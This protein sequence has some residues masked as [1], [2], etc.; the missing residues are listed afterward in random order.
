[1]PFSL[2]M[3]AR[4]IRHRPRVSIVAAGGVAVAV[5]V[6]VIVMGITGGLHDYLIGRLLGLEAHLELLAGVDLPL[7]GFEEL[8]LAVGKEPYVQSVEPYVQGQVLVGRPGSLP[9]GAY[10]RGLEDPQVRLA[11]YLTVNSQDE[12]GI[13]IGEDLAMA[14][15]LEPGSEAV[16]IGGLENSRSFAVRGLFRTGLEGYDGGMVYLTLGAAQEML[17]YSPYEVAG[18]AVYLDDPLGA[19]QHAASLQALTGLW[20]RSWQDKHKDVLATA[21]VQQ[22]ALLIIVLATFAVAGIGV[23]NILWLNVWEKRRDIG[24]LQALGAKRGLLARVFFWQG[25]LL[26]AVGIVLGLVLG[27][28]LLWLLKGRPIHVPELTFAQQ[29]P[30]LIK[31]KDLVLAGG[32]ALMV[33][34]GAGLAAAREAGRQ[35]IVE[36]LVHE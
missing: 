28:G 2:W 27:L 8:L 23:G 29:L 14:L 16:I 22:R 11:P 35:K 15:G 4:Y 31:G 12:E 33:A 5:A 24:V 25:I 36:V 26:G 13:F 9:R 7:A 30:V 17:G 32:A 19:G 1:M 34:G 21:Q 18:L 20:V 3:A 10:L 6:M